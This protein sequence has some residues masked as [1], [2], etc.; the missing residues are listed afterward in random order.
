VD[1]LDLTAREKEVTSLLL[2]GDSQKMIAAKLN[3]SFSTVSFHIR[4]LYRKL[5]IQS[6]GELFALFLAEGST[7][8]A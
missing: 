1:S 2:A 5:N 3:V 7:V 6:K 4:N 8:V